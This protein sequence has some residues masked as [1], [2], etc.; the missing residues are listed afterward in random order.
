MRING[1]MQLSKLKQRDSNVRTD[2]RD[3][4]DDS[5]SGV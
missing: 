1:Q 4:M 5:S 3:Q 2:D